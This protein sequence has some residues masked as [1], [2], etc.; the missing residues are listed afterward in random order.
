MEEVR[1]EPKE[2]EAATPIDSSTQLEVPMKGGDKHLYKLTM[3]ADQ[4]ARVVADQ[5]G[6]DVVVHLYAPDGTLQ[7]EIDSPIGPIGPE[8]VVLIGSPAGAYGIE[9]T[10]GEGVDPGRYALS[11]PELRA[12]KGDDRLR[13]ESERTFA[14]AEGLRRAGSLQEALEKYRDLETFWQQLNDKNRMATNF[15]RIGDISN[16][17]GRLDDAIDAYRKALPLVTE[18]GDRLQRGTLLNAVGYFHTRRAEFEEALDWLR[19]AWS[20]AM[21]IGRPDFKAGVLVNL[22][23]AYNYLGQSQ[24][25]LDTYEEALQQAR[26]AGVATN[27]EKKALFGLGNILV[28]L[29]RPDQAI[30]PLQEVLEI[31][32]E[33]GSIRNQA[34]VINSIGDVYN[35]L[36]DYEKAET[37]LREALELR[38]KAGDQVGRA[39]TLN[40]LGTIHLK[41][42]NLEE[43]RAC[44]EE[45]LQIA[46]SVK[47][48]RDEAFALL[49]LGRYFY[50]TGNDGQA[51][52]SFDRAEAIF[53]EIGDDRGYASTLFGCARSLHRLGDYAGSSDRLSRSLEAVEELRGESDSTDLRTGYF[54]TKQHYYDLYIDVLMHLHERNPSGGFD[55]QALQMAERR[56]A[57]GLLEMLNAAGTDIRRSK[58]AGLSDQE[59][60]I[61]EQLNA[62]GW[63]LAKL[64]ESSKEKP[65]LENRE[66]KLL[67]ELDRVRTRLRVAEPAFEA[68]THPIPL[69]LDEIQRD[70]LD[71]DTLLLVYS[72]GEERS[73]LW[74]ISDQGVLRSFVLSPRGKVEEVAEQVLKGWRSDIPRI[75]ASTPQMAAT[76]SRTLLSPVEHLLE[77]KRLAVVAEGALQYIPFGALPDSRRLDKGSEAP[78][79]LARN[80]VV[81]LPSASVLATLRRDLGDRVAAPRRMAVVADPVFEVDDP[82]LAETGTNAADALPKPA[83][84]DLERAA[85][86]MGIDSFRRLP[87]SREEA[88]A[89]EEWVSEDQ[90]LEALD[91]DANRELV[92]SGALRRY[93]VLHFATHGLLNRKHPEMS[94]LVLSL[95]DREGHPIDGFLRLHEIY[96]LDLPADLVVLSACQTGL[97]QEVRGEGLIGLTRGFMYA[98]A[99]RV[100]VSL[101]NVDDEATAE[102]MIRF[103]RGLFEKRLSPSRALRCAQVSMWEDGRWNSPNAWAGFIFNGEWALKVRSIDDPIEQ[104]ASGS[105][106]IDKSDDDLPPPIIGTHGGCPSLTEGE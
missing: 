78:P 28:Y 29:G 61:Q 65:S 102:L 56:R 70:V 80:E 76:L 35:R 25:A 55:I 8:E 41:M 19:Q 73:F 4:Y 98:G 94:G 59:K 58:N 26:S 84:A 92:L 85:R 23:N 60:S 83:S 63:Q 13:V 1:I 82:R 18:L 17:L 54:T 66:T 48:P 10:A 5:D 64:A 86:E 75:G 103:Y 32:R 67:A 51:V 106:M 79:L 37:M 36:G 89:I 20:V 42:S 49:N 9:V 72:L 105:G 90:R 99:P 77:D 69:R 88:L 12:A 21:E 14:Q 104:L 97:G 2:I 52:E 43:A 40:S 53:R 11:V 16:A 74:C 46:R 95:F 87:H 15:R 62:V 93:R 34:T 68:L 100:I 39:T 71:E 57:R 27:E 24:K 81:S 30:G 96:G 6:I 31:V 101:W 44:Y 3:G 91:F 45:A 22:G 33:A 47:S 7:T 50:A 38:D